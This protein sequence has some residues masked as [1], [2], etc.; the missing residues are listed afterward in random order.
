MKEL[1]MFFMGIGIGL[2]GHNPF[3]Y[4]PMLIA[5]VFVGLDIWMDYLHEQNIKR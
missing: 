2:M 5:I 4:I 1:G 3:W